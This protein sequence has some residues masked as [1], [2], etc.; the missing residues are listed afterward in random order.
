M[1]RAFVLSVMYYEPDKQIV[2][3]VFTHADID[4]IARDERVTVIV[5]RDKIA[6]IFDGK[7]T[8]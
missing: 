4:T 5:K 3:E 6:D 8:A 7:G 2:S 1:A